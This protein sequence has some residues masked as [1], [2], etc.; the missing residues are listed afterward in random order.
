MARR[1]RQRPGERTDCGQLRRYAYS[2]SMPDDEPRIAR[3]VVLGLAALGGA[4]LIAADTR[5]PAPAPARV[6]LPVDGE[7]T[8]VRVSDDGFAGHAEPYLAVNPT[9]P[10]NLLGACIAFGDDTAITAYASFDTGATWLNL[11]ALADSRGGRD[12]TVSFD[13]AGRGYV[14]A[15]TDDLHVWRT[16]NGGRTFAEP[17]LA[18]R[19]RKLDHPWLAADPAPGPPA[20]THLFAA[21]TG[22]DD[23]AH[24]EFARS[25]DAGRSFQEPLV[26]DTVRGSDEANLTSPMLA[27]GAGTVHVIYG[28][29][30]PLPKTALRPEFATPIRVISSTDRGRTWGEPVH[31]GTGV[32]EFRVAAETNV[33]GL[34]SVAAHGTRDLAAAAFVV[35]RP[36]EPGTDVAVCLS[37]DRGRTWTAPRLVPRDADDASYLQPQLAVDETGGLAL[38]AFAYRHGTVDVV[39]FL[40]D[41][42]AGQPPSFG[43]PVRVTRR[44]FDPTTGTRQGKHGRWWIGDYQG[45]T[46]AAGHVRPFWNDPRTGRLEILTTSMPSR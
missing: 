24:L 42:T 19:G 44:P 25:T 26:L 1:P 46:S 3:R 2:V 10:R 13:A 20:A 8:V 27:A 17:V 34:P 41:A 33:P 30:P 14:C 31:L 5:R 15:N 22:P 23:N 18:T 40:A 11:G 36:G 16:D 32:M 45:L 12:P 4:G 9:D 37:R 38:S 29:W 21:W 28:V 43:P 35:R 39:V 7:P 6:A